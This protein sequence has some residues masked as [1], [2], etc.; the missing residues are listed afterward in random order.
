MVAMTDPAAA[1]AAAIQH[2]E[3]PVGA[4]YPPIQPFI[5]RAAAILAALP[6]HTL[7]PASGL[8]GLRE[9]LQ[10]MDR[11]D[12]AEP[13]PR[14]ELWAVVEAA[15]DLVYGPSEPEEEQRHG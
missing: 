8:R 13:T 10:A 15:R 2:V 5:E 7:V 3:T 6:D 14:S 11:G 9:S 12:S 1:L 4:I